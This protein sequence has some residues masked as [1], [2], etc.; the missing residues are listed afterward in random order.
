MTQEE[1]SKI[2]Q[3]KLNKSV[4]LFYEGYSPPQIG[5]I[6]H[7][8]PQK[9]RNHLRQFGYSDMN[10]DTGLHVNIFKEIDTEEKA[11]WLGFLYADGYIR[12]NSVELSLKDKEHVEKFK[13][14]TGSRCKICEKHIKLNNK[15]YVAYRLNMRNKEFAHW[16]YDKGMHQNKSLSITYPSCIPNEFNKDFIRGY[17]DGNGCVCEKNKRNMCFSFCSGSEKFITSLREELI[18]NEIYCSKIYAR[19]GNNICFN[20][21][22]YSN[23]NNASKFYD[24]IYKDATI[25]L[26][27]KFNKS[28][29]IKNRIERK[30]NI[31]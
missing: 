12:E 24:Y 2:H 22:I 21:N 29:S 4:E 11:Y 23:F 25:Y 16:L 17:F 5:K 15:E 30:K 18:K 8:S 9:V 28:T 27:R 3:D 31:A 14:F 13:K 19:T 26:D 10:I 7:V 1:I 20:F 6:L